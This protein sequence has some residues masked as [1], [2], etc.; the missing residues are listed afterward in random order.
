MTPPVYTECV[1]V[2]QLSVAGAHTLYTVPA[3]KVF[4]LTDLDCTQLGGATVQMYLQDVATG[5][6][7][8]QFDSIGSNGDFQYRG[9][10]AFVAG[11]SLGVYITGGG[12][13]IR[14]TGYLLSA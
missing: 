12:W 6:N 9:R 8:R 11:T 7:F 13:H 10:Q 3:D 14:V 4:I 2:G 1:Y 5:T